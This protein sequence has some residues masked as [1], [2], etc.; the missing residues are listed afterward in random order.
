[1]VFAMTD[2]SAE[3][4]EKIFFVCKSVAN[5][6]NGKHQ[7]F[8]QKQRISEPYDLLDAKNINTH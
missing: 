8:F 4:T 2:V 5:N 1:M 6:A 7:I 3:I